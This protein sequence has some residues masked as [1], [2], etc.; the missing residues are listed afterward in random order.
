MEL[1]LRAFLCGCLAATLLRGAPPDSFYVNYD[2][3]VPTASLRLHPISI[4][5]P[6]ANVDLAAA[7]QAGN[8]VLAYISV[9]ELANDAAYRGE[10]IKQGLRFRGR[11]E[12]WDSDILDLGDARWIELIVEQVAVA[13]LNKGYDGFFLDTLDS[14]AVADRK[15]GIALLK[16]LREKT[17][18]GYILANRGFDMLG[19]L[20]GVVDGVLVESVFGTF[21]FEKKVYESVA[22]ADTKYLVD[23]LKRLEQTGLDVFVL[24][25]ADPNAPNRAQEIARKI[26]DEGWAPFVST[27]EL[28]G[29]ALAP[30]REVPRRVFSFYG[31]LALEPIDKIIWPADTFTFLRL[32]TL[33][34]WLGYEVD[35]GKVEAGVPL[36]RLGP[37]TAAIIIPKDWEIPILEEG[38]VVDWLIKQKNRGRKILIWGS[39]PFSEEVHRSRFLKA[40]G[41]GGTGNVIVPVK[42]LTQADSDAA[43]MENAE[44]K[45]RLLPTD[46]IDLQAPKGS[47]LI[48]S[49][50]AETMAGK[51]MRLDA[52]FTTS[53]GGAAFDPYLTFQRPDF[54]ELW[55]FDPF[56]YLEAALGRVNAPLPDSTTKA[57]KR[58]FLSHIDGDGF[59]NKSETSIGKYSSEVV[60]DE[61]LKKY[62]LPVTVSVIEAEVRVQIEGVDPLLAPKFED[63]AR[64]IFALPNV[65]MASHSYSHPFMWIPD[66]RTAY[67]YKRANLKLTEHYP[68]VD[69]A[70][71]IEGSVAYINR[72]LAPEGKQVEVFLWS[73]NCRP[74]PEALRRVHDLGL[75]AMNGG[76]TLISRRVPTLNGVA[77]RSISWGDQL[78]VLA[79]NQ[80]E[81]IYT[82]DWEGP[83]YGTFVNVLETFERTESPRRLK[84]VNIYYHF[85]SADFFSSLRALKVIHDWAME[86][87]LHAIKVSDYVNLASDARATKLYSKGDD[88]WAMVNGGDLQTFRVPGDWGKRIDL[89]RSRG[90]QGWTEF[91]GSAYVHTSDSPVTTLKLTPAGRSPA[92]HWYLESSSAPI[93]FEIFEARQLVFS[94]DDLRPATVVLNGFKKDQ[95]LNVS[96]D[97]QA[98]LLTADSEGRLELRLS[99]V[100]RVQVRENP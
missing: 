80:N 54:R 3:N 52:I 69:L 48:H 73:G 5:H 7:H 55:K 84:P 46:F 24:D 43:I 76:D 93:D 37:E 59:V 91:Q 85:Y 82:N 71:E 45:L 2:V 99:P 22:P 100:A 30:W 40:L 95:S 35:Y 56:A 9:G 78:Q 17:P 19:D 89:A 13:A 61:I 10:A 31:N 98:Q 16:R 26:S 36:P 83:F 38:R 79:P 66:D 23:R 88:E 12:V 96:I 67:L 50:E 58:I 6:D 47:R 94:V 44:T 39:L 68:R 49:V 27:P 90:V 4:V 18:T 29:A 33:V 32:Q 74:P 97:D 34:E 14:I 86:E 60:R 41:M 53:W 70:R 11:N 75:V 25:Y 57:G 64:D 1:R 72:E 21:D 42:N 65:E 15:D 8:K 20:K 63:I 28:Q 92:A 77:P 81:N 62:P 51:R 87:D